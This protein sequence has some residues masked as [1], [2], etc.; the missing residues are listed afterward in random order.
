MKFVKIFTSLLL[1]M[2][3]TQVVFAQNNIGEKVI[4]P[5]PQAAQIGKYGGYTVNQSTGTPNINIPIYTAKEG[6]LSIPV[7]LAY[8]YKGFRPSDEPGWVGLGFSLS[9]GGAITR[10]IKSTADE[11]VAGQMAKVKTLVDGN[12]PVL[13][14]YQALNLTGTGNNY[15]ESEPDIFSFQFDGLSG[16]FVIDENG[17]PRVISSQKIVFA[18]DESAYGPE[19]KQVITKWTVTGENGNRYVFDAFEVSFQ[20]ANA[21]YIF[22]SA[23][24]LTEMV[25]TN[26]DKVT[27]EYTA[28]DDTK[29]RVQAGIVDQW[30]T[31]GGFSSITKNYTREIYLQKIKGSVWEMVFDSEEINAGIVEGTNSVARK[32]NNIQLKNTSVTPNVTTRQFNFIYK[33]VSA[34][35]LTLQSVGEAGLPPHTFEYFN[36]IPRDVHGNTREVDAW[37]YYNGWANPS[38]IPSLPGVDLNPRTNLTKNGALV[39]VIYPTSG[40]T[41]FEYEQ[42]EY[43][44]IQNTVSLNSKINIENHDYFFRNLFGVITQNP[45]ASFTL[46]ETTRVDIRFSAASTSPANCTN[47][48][49][50]GFQTFQLPA[51]TYSGNDLLKRSTYTPC[52]LIFGNCSDPG[53]PCGFFPPDGYDVALTVKIFRVTDTGKPYYGGIRLSKMTDTP[54]VP[55]GTATV[56][57]YSYESDTN[58]ALSSGVIVQEPVYDLIIN[59]QSAPS[60]RIVR[61]NPFNPVAMT[62]I[63]YRY[64]KETNP[65]Y[66]TL[67]SFTSHIEQG[68]LAG[69]WACTFDF[70]SQLGGIFNQNSYLE[71]GDY[72]FY[73]FMRGLPKKTVVQDLSGNKRQQTDVT[74]AGYSSNSVEPFKVASFYHELLTSF[75]YSSGGSTQTRDIYYGKGYYVVG[76]WPRKTLE[77]ITNYGS[78][79]ASP[80][81]TTINYEYAN[82]NHRQLTKQRTTESDGSIE[83]TNYKYPLDYSASSN[84]VI[85]SMIAANMVTYPLE[86]V[87]WLEKSPSDR[88]VI[89][90][91]VTT[92]NTF[93]GTPSNHILPYKKFRFNGLNGSIG[94]FA[95]YDGSSNEN[96]SASYRETVKFTHYDNQGNPLSL[97]LNGGEKISYL[98]SYKGQH[99][100]AEIQNADNAEVVSALGG[101]TFS[102][103]ADMTDSPAIK[104]KLD[105][106]RTALSGS[107]VTS[108]QYK[109]T[110]GI[111]AITDPAGKNL[112]Y[113]YDTFGRLTYIKDNTGKVRSSFCYNYAGQNI[114]C[115]STVPTGVVQ[116]SA[117][118]LLADAATCGYGVT[119]TATDSLP[120]M[121]KSIV[122]T[123]V[124]AGTDCSGVTYTWTGLGV[125]GAG[126]SKTLFAPG[127]TGNF[128]YIV[129]ANK[130]GCSIKRDTI[131]LA[132]KAGGTHVVANGCYTIGTYGAMIQ[133]EANSVGALM[134]VYAP[135]GASGQIFQLTGVDTDSYKILSAPSNL[136]LNPIN[137]Q[138]VFPGGSRIQTWTNA[139]Y[140]KW[141]ISPWTSGGYQ[142]SSKSNPALVHELGG[143]SSAN[144]NPLAFSTNIGGGH[145]IFTLTPT[146][147]PAG[148]G[149]ECEFNIT[150][151][152][153]NMSPV[154]GASVT[155]STTCGGGG[156][157]GVTYS[158][159]GIGGAISGASP[160]IKAP[161]STGSFTYTVTASKAGCTS[162]TATVTINVQVGGG[163]VL[164]NGCYT[165]G[166]Y[167][168]ML[169]PENNNNNAFLRIYNPSGNTNQLFELTGVDTDV[170]KIRSVTSGFILN[171]IGNSAVYP[172]AIL[173]QAWANV[174]YQ[175]WFISPWSAGI[176]Q[177]ANK[178]NTSLVAE[179]GGGN[180]TNGSLV[181][182]S[183]NIGGGHQRFTFT[184]VS[185]PTARMAVEEIFTPPAAQAQ[186]LIYPNPVKDRLYLEIN[187]SVSLKN[188]Q[189]FNLKGTVVFET[190]SLPED[191]IDVSA[192]PEGAYLIKMVFTNGS[193]ATYRIVKQ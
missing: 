20:D 123:A 108:Y 27:F 4:F 161:G 178:S 104:T 191:G 47:L 130:G 76:G 122:L 157:S 26:G 131:T 82:A 156:C 112:V 96:A 135:S 16:K 78:D 186:V 144:G 154:M 12:T 49:G 54:V 30:G 106:V 167:G 65:V 89:D 97:L 149:T 126:A 190:A 124:C 25:S 37:G 72:Q 94:T 101:T 92:Y 160:T 133:P 140:Q 67:H 95:N 79:G 46:T 141:Y 192:L 11:I 53:D 38:L 3:S 179:L 64:V 5:S 113:E 189:L 34:V 185:C 132:V 14:N 55:G 150:A 29:R 176:Y 81:T 102:Q 59:P 109:P 36:T 23:W 146:T 136:V 182:F 50:S 63:Y 80:V 172:G 142:I 147:C 139:D 175:K 42:N 103:M 31:A 32:L 88:K 56:T 129:T 137:N 2:G 107:L 90:A 43:S 116:P 70:D 62:P 74:Y 170:Y 184:P 166:T 125:S 91:N 105:A 168:V 39:K 152:S 45:N 8:N 69:K 114:A 128:Q 162:R 87:T 83:E 51:G 75:S 35:K 117:A 121:G 173:L 110:Q 58:P 48:N 163:H 17:I 99:P 159:S 73:D 77:T 13:A 22:P 153:S 100:V 10:V 57:T 41:E 60:Q 71:F 28:K 68:D 145:Q 193:A 66:Q 93:T 1:I 164:A 61:S 143:G 148:T 24:Y 188:L 84:A 115:G 138:A 187:D 165:I 52:N 44:Y 86:Q 183:T 85:Q 180:T 18:Y 169:Q 111:S 19:N 119:A 7:S 151:V 158:W 171:P 21:M 15:Q 6:A 40:T 181:T 98:W 118:S 177:I 134:R 127:S 155:L 33:D 9:A 120:T 174:D